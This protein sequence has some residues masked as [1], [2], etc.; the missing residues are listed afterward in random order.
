MK[1]GSAPS[2]INISI[3]V[4]NNFSRRIIV[5][6]RDHQ[7]ALLINTVYIQLLENISRL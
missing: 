5:F 4:E 7:F 3:S 6:Y 1:V 2:V